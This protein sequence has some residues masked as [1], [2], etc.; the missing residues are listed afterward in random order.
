MMENDAYTIT[1]ELCGRKYDARCG[2]YYYQEGN[3]K[4]TRKRK[5][6]YCKIPLS[7]EYRYANHI[8]AFVEGGNYI[9]YVFD[10]KDDLTKFILENTREEFIVC[11]DCENC[12]IDVSTK[13]K[14]WWV[15]GYVNI[16]IDLPN[17]KEKVI[18]LY[19]ENAFE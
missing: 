5:C 13:R 1:C 2:T 18:E 6:R 15:R 8:P 9:T 11:T 10:S 19:G 12:I 14:Y 7:G 3:D 17:W 4:T 16:A